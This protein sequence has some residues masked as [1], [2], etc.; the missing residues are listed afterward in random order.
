[1][2]VAETAA[3][4]TAVNVGI[5]LLFAWS[6]ISR[7][8]GSDAL[9]GRMFSLRQVFP[10]R[11]C[12]AAVLSWALGTLASLP[13][14]MK[15]AKSLA[16][17][18]EQ[19]ERLRETNRT[20]KSISEER[21]RFYANMRHEMR[22]PLNSIIRLC[23][24]M[25]RFVDAQEEVRKSIEKIH[26]ASLTLLGVVN[27]I[28][29][30]SEK[31]NKGIEL[32]PVEYDVPSLINDIVML[33]AIRIG[34][35]PITFDTDIDGDLP[36]KL[37]G[38][39]LRVELVCNSLLAN[40]L[41]F[42]KQGSI[43]ISVSH[44]MEG[45]SDWLIIRV[46][47][48]GSGFR[49]EGLAM[50]MSGCGT[51]KEAEQDYST[52]E[53]ITMLMGG[54]IT[55]ESAY[56]KGSSFTAYIPQGFVTD[57][58][59]GEEFAENLKRFRL[60]AVKQFDDVSPGLITF[61]GMRVLV[62]DDVEANLDVARE[63]LRPYGMSVDCL[64]S[65][66]KAVD[67]IR[68][69]KVKYDAIFMDHMMPDL[70]GISAVRVIRERVGTKYARDIPIIALTA[71][72]YNGEEQMFLE[73][74][75]Q[76]LLPKPIDSARLDEILRRWLWEKDVA[77]APDAQRESEPDAGRLPSRQWEPLAEA[78]GACLNNIAHAGLD[79]ASVPIA[80]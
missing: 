25:I 24:H 19:N 67:C 59:I 70:D 35:R 60:P 47:D 79:M 33:N 27:D 38:D 8:S 23:E 6:G 41:R 26:D 63:L 7:A 61:P 73:R 21:I 28:L 46:S 69:G 13:A 9:A 71:N 78:K 5:I 17:I 76:A 37:F 68:E 62:V 16:G 20:V 53:M 44:K 39:D 15:L 56:G 22:E 72:A 36:R 12:L 66:W 54:T 10:L 77:E 58:V 31:E 45:I 51:L 3:I 65:G 64:S 57:A 48:T 52:A 40:A 30:F 49:P 34:D 74:G 14:A 50:F 42:T 55:A 29:G 43:G 80:I 1:M 32:M 2:S 4:I 11:Y 18:E 75:F